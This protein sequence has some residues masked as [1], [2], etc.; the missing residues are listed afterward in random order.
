MRLQKVELS[1]KNLVKIQYKQVEVGINGIDD[2]ANVKNNKESDKP[3]HR[4]LVDA[5]Q[6]MAPHLLFQTQLIDHKVN[7]PADME[8]E[9]WF[10]GWHFDNDSRFEG[11]R[12]T[13][14]ETFGKDSVEGIRLFGEKVNEN[15]DKCPLKTGVIY[16]DREDPT[17]YPL[18]HIVMTQF[19]TL[20]FECDLNLKGKNENTITNQMALFDK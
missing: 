20:D 10:Q 17:H 6:K 8:P 2:A 3:A 5:M 14:V 18:N 1:K 7:I 11:V 4:H 16:W 19:E 9:E 13:K 15:G 12:V